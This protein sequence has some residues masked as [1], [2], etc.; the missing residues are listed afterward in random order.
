MSTTEDRAVAVEYA[1]SAPGSLVL[2]LTQV[3]GLRIACGVRHTHMLMCAY[4][5]ER[6]PCGADSA[7]LHAHSRPCRGFSTAA[8]PSRG[9]LSMLKS[10]KCVFRP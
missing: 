3:C 2:E 4:P 5:H 1:S 9:S 7:E 10:R 8:H 6:A